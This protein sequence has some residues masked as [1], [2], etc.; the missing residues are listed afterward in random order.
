MTNV[1]DSCIEQTLLIDM[2]PRY[3]IEA[4]FDMG[5]QVRLSGGKYGSSTGHGLLIG[6]LSKN[7]LDS[8]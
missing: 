3:R 7:V 1:P 5:W 8:C 4:S 6:A 2:Q